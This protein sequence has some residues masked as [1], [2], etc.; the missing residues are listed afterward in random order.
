MKDR[1]YAGAYRGEFQVDIAEPEG[2]IVK[3]YNLL[4][5]ENSS[6]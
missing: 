4:E 1:W 3:S 6:I 5:E 2:V